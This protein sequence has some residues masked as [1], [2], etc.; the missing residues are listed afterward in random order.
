MTNVAQKET[1]FA[2]PVA[3]HRGRV[4]LCTGL[5]TA[6]VFLLMTIGVQL[7]FIAPSFTTDVVVNLIFGLPVLLLPLV[8]LW[9]A[10]GENRT[11]LDKAAELTL[12]YLPYTAGSQI[13]YELVFL[14]GHPLGLWAPTTDPGW[15]WLWWQYGLADTR[16]VSGNPWI[17]ALEVVGV[18]TGVTVFAMWTRLIRPQLTTERRIRCLWTTFAGVAILMSSTAVYFIAEMGAG[19]S[20]IGQG[21]FGLG[22]KFVAE[23]IP[24]IVLPP[25]V[26]YS[27]YLQI[28]YLTRRAAREVV[29]P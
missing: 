10:P 19:F 14:V 13:G 4:Y 18:L 25:L 26:L 28:D 27:I 5:F 9:D 17:F 22:F 16:Y 11:R 2:R 3:S 29:G 20:D 23:N 6:F 7:G 12:F 1:N 21:A 8:I 15:K 24:F